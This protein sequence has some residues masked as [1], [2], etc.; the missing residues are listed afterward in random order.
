[1]PDQVRPGLATLMDINMLVMTPGGRER[2][3]AE[4]RLL[5]ERAG[6][7]LQQAHPA[8]PT[9]YAVLEAVKA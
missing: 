3:L 9:E 5:F 1:M 7:K 4:F 2:T 6:F 8:A